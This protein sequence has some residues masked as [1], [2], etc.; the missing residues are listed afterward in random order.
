V[1]AAVLLAFAGCENTDPEPPF[2]ADAAEA[3]HYQLPVIF[4][5]FQDASDSGER[6]SAARAVAIID[7]CNKYFQNKKA[8]GS[9]DMN[10]EFIAA[11]ADPK[12]KPLS[13]GGIH[14]VTVSNPT[15][16]FTAFM[17]DKKNIEYLWDPNEYI[18]VMVYPFRSEAN[19]ET[20]TL[21]AAHLPYTVRPD[22]LD[23]LESTD[24]FLTLENL[25]YPHCIS[26]NKTYINEQESVVGSFYNSLD[27]VSALAHELGH[28]LGLHHAFNEGEG[29]DLDLCANTDYCD[30]TPAYNRGEYLDFLDRYTPISGDKITLEDLRVLTLRKDCLTHEESTPNNVMD[31]DI[32]WVNRF[33]TDQRARVRYV[34]ARSP[35]V[36]G[37]KV[38]KGAATRSVSGPIDLPMRMMKCTKRR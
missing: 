26:L 23:G 27:P 30:D 32:S 31:Y 25:G 19:A 37:P 24:V 7:G 15:M 1:L 21:G 34:L 4:H 22:H 8:S 36:P 38:K 3:H 29:D 13:E 12:G 16:D 18:N 11:T 2:T 20:F 35:L 5:V 9:V 33:T 14:R 6:M 17:K 28:Y 10:L